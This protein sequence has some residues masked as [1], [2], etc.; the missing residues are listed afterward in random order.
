MRNNF[1]IISKTHKPFLNYDSNLDI[2]AKIAETDLQHEE[3]RLK[4]KEFDEKINFID[5]S[6]KL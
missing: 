4:R 5:N 2:S 6:H 1:R 3:Q